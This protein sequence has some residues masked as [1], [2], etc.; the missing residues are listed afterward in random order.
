MVLLRPPLSWASAARAQACLGPQLSVVG[1]CGPGGGPTH[2]QPL[3]QCGGPELQASRVEGC[4]VFGP[5]SR[6][7]PPLGDSSISRDLEWTVQPWQKMGSAVRVDQLP[8]G[9]A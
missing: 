2:A 7:S 8:L 3:R 9:Q 1:S 4:E 6:Q 5:R